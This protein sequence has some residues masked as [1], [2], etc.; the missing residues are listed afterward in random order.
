[1]AIRESIFW[2]DA[3]T[4]EVKEAWTTEF[5]MSTSGVFWSRDINE[6]KAYRLELL[7]PADEVYTPL[8]YDEQCEM[9][10]S[11]EL[12]MDREGP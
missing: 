4:D 5:Y 6:V 8:T 9:H 12:D 3:R 2:Y 7:A 11:G 1:M 10:A